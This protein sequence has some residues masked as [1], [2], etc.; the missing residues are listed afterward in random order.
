MDVRLTYSYKGTAVEGGRK[1]DDDKEVDQAF[2]VYLRH[3]RVTR[4]IKDNQEVTHTIDYTV[5]PD[6]TVTFILE[7]YFIGTASGVLVVRVD[8]EG[9]LAYGA[10]IPTVLP[11]PP[12]PEAA[13]APTP[14]KPVTDKVLITYVDE[15]GELIIPD[16]NGTHPGKS[17][18]GYEI[19][20]T[21]KD[22]KRNVRNIYRKVVAPAQIAVKTIPAKPE[23]VT[24]QE[25]PNTG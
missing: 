23:K 10:Y 22:K 7:K 2:N 13:Y 1:F 16:K 14:T 21:E 8:T 25:L 17:L 19:V 11:T 24:R 12:A 15:N 20:R 9:K 6:G 5:K 3:K 18:E 4:N